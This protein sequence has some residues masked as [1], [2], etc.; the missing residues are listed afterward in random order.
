M[1]RGVS[2]TEMALDIKNL[3]FIFKVLSLFRKDKSYSLIKAL[4]TAFKMADGEKIVR[5]ENLYVISSFLPPF[6]SRALLSQVMAVEDTKNIYTEQMMARRS[7]PISF[8]ICVTNRCNY[9]C[10]HCSA[11]GRTEDR[12]LSTD[13]WIKAIRDIQEMNTAIIGF[14]G[15]EPLL[16]DDL[17]RLIGT[18]DDRSITYLFTNGRKLSYER[19]LSLKKSGLF[20]LAV[21]LD[22][23]DPGIHNEIRRDKNAFDEALEAIRSSRKAGLYTMINTVLFK[24][25]LSEKE[26]FDL[27]RLAE[28][29]GV[30]EVRILEPITSGSLC[31][32]ERDGAVFFTKD[33]RMKLALFQEKVNRRNDLP[34]LTIFAYD[35]SPERYGCGAGTQHSYLSASGDLYPCD[36]VPLS[37]GNIIEESLPRL[38]KEMTEAIG[39]PKGECFALQAGAKIREKG[40]GKIPLRKE[41]SMELCSKCK[42]REYP[43]IYRIMQGKKMRQ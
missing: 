25:R 31:S 17:E 42:A 41:D 22:S 37:F 5:F 3:T 20:G 8:Y 16:R 35:E 40:G 34:K 29:Q 4:K 39:L 33:D 13:E 1:A 10:M 30:M 11:R 23:A 28:A 9:N 12:E 2:L 26:I 36:F 27:L 14:T 15:G 18:I 21:S 6:P 7:A 38:W 19:A 32:E 24:E 43:G